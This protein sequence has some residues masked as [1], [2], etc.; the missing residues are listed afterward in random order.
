MEPTTKLILGDKKLMK[1][2]IANKGQGGDDR[3]L[4]VNG[5]GDTNNPT[6]EY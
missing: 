6:L 5:F 1:S 2:T 3:V 4:V